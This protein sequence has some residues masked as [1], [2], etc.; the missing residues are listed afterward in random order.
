MVVKLIS[1]N[2]RNS[3]LTKLKTGEKLDMNTTIEEINTYKP[4]LE[5]DVIQDAKKELAAFKL[6]NEDERAFQKLLKLR[7]SI[8]SAFTN[9]YRI[10]TMRDVLKENK[11][12]RFAS[13][14]FENVD[15]DIPVF[16]FIMDFPE[17][18]Y[19]MKSLSDDAKNYTEK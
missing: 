19:P 14:R 5:H 17:D 9:K 10:L 2:Y 7:S 11:T 13:A 18:K 12:V 6:S 3:S 16:R 8:N 4:R 1:K 15:K